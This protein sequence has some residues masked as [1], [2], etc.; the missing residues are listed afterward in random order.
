MPSRITPTK[1]SVA[2]S[3]IPKNN[4]YH[5]SSIESHQQLDKFESPYRK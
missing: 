3:V 2:P 1:Y 4:S 5:Q